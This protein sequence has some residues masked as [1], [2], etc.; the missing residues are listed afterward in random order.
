MKLCY[1]G[2][3]YDYTPPTLEVTESELMGCYRGRLHH[4]SYVRHMPCP[5]PISAMQFRGHAYQT[6][7]EGGFESLATLPPV[8]TV[9]ATPSPMVQARRQL[10]KEATR[11]HQENIRRSLDRRMA[12]AAA[13]GNR[14]LLSQL[15]AEKH[16]LA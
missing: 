7:A 15:E 6:K 1:R 12:V 14:S 13:Q 5:Q 8:V 2:V 16:L 10:L 4:F 11:I 3:D 9:P